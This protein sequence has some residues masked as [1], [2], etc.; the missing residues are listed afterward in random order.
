MN[1]SIKTNAPV[2][3]VELYKRYQTEASLPDM[4]YRLINKQQAIFRGLVINLSAIIKTISQSSIIPNSIVI[5]ADVVIVPDIKWTMDSPSL[6]IYARRVEFSGSASMLFNKE[7]H[8]ASFIIYSAE[9]M[10]ELTLLADDDLTET[11]RLTAD[12]IDK[13]PGVH[14]RFSEGKIKTLPIDYKQGIGQKADDNMEIYLTNLFIT[15]SLLYSDYPSIALI[16]L[17]WIKQWAFIPEGMEM[18]Y[19]RSLTLSNQ[20]QGEIE[21]SM[22][23]S[24]F[25]PY[26]SK[27][28]YE[29]LADAFTKE[30]VEYENKYMHLLTL[31][32]LTQENIEIVKT[33]INMSKSEKDYITSL[34]KQANDNYKSAQEAVT[35]A[36]A[37]FY[38]Q[39][40]IVKFL[41]IDFE[42]QGIPQYQRQ[43]IV[44]AIV[45]LVT[46]V[47]Q[48][49][50]AIASMAGGNPAG[51]GAAANAAVSTAESIAKAAE[52]TKEVAETAKQ[53]ADTMKRLKELVKLLKDIYEF[54]DQ[55]FIFIKN[56]QKAIKERNVIDKMKTL[57]DASSLNV[58][59]TWDAYILQVDNMMADP[60]S[61]GIGYAA[62][63]KEALDILAIYGKSMCKAELAVIKT[64][65]EM[66]TITFQ[67][68]YARQKEK[69]LEKLVSNLHAGQKI[70]L[71][72]MQ[73]LCQ[74]YLDSKSLLFNALKSYQSS[75][76]YWSFRESDIKP[77]IS[78]KI[79]PLTADL[80]EMTQIAMDTQHAMEEFAPHPPQLL[81]NGI[82]EI[83]DPAIIESLRK[84]G[85]AVWN[86]PLDAEELNGLER[87]RLETIRIW[88]EGVEFTSKSK[89]VLIHLENTGNYADRF[90]G[91]QYQ[92]TSRPLKRGF[93]YEVVTKEKGSA[94]QFDNGT[95]GLV[96]LDGKVDKEVAYAYFQPTP[97]SEWSIS[98]IKSN[99]DS[100]IDLS[101][102]S[103][104]TFWFEG[105]AI[106]S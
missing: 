51:G 10:G 67:L 89:T 56:I 11:T 46:S 5:Y 16:Q 104:I 93:E 71:K 25:I 28:V 83:T 78:S 50:A 1:T 29:K 103:K 79:N 37:N 22:K 47:A 76:F 36:R 41:A 24:R 61:K 27:V 75:Y 44:K 34:L 102:V 3:W 30:I 54:A 65:Q 53:A 98:L 68:E 31:N 23:S 40:E 33:M 70:P 58:I 18:L 86:I 55:I 52:T 59:D 91:K 69:E 63:Y 90:K 2:Q 74:K 57:T 80:H 48:F 7:R 42:K 17:I 73:Q 105:T 77:H 9:W 45:S 60:I 95:Y 81:K 66:A 12:I 4:D 20:L 100:T 6:I 15:A 88:L 96:K 106:T 13:S 26:L 97:F 38:K 35:M 8:Q 39:E 101:G 85:K 99:D 64:C 32:T 72:I 87:V 21:A 49:G 92:F 94:H 84:E 14:I 82:Y 62:K 43:Q 19:Y